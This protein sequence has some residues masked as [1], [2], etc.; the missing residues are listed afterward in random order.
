M[1]K[2][3]GGAGRAEA[4]AAIPGD[5]LEPKLSSGDAELF[6]RRCWTT[7]LLAD[8]TRASLSKL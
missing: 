6:H 2:R 8:V 4:A 1:E 3:V 7:A 5:M